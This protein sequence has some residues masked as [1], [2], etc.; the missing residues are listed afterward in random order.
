MRTSVTTTLCA[1]ALLGVALP[2]LAT[3]RIKDIAS[4]RGVRDNQLIGYGLVVGLNG[5]GD[6]TGTEFT[7]QSLAG[8]LAGMGITVDA[9]EIQVKNVAAVI[10]TASLPP[11]ARAGSTLDAMVSSL[12]DATSLEGGTLAMTP[13]YGADGEVFAV[14]Q[15]P[16]SVGG[17][18]EQGG[19]GSSVTKNHPTVGR[20]AS[21]ALVERELAF[22]LTDRRDFTLA[23]HDPD[24]TT[25]RRA[26]LAIN[27]AI[28]AEV[29]ES[30]DSGTLHVSMPAEWSAGV[31]DFLARVEAV[32]LQPDR[33]ARVVFNERT[34]T[35]VMGAE[36]TISKVA[37]AHGSLAVSIGIFNDVSQPLPFSEGQT[38][39][40]TNDEVEV[41]EE[42]ARLTVV[43]GP[44][45]IEEL[46]R[47]LNAIGVTPRDLIAILQAIKAAG[48]LPA[49]L[50]LM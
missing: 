14:A 33:V 20:V 30:G 22:S 19:G 23:L 15:G 2:A 41:E 11:F 44:V 40:V 12:G 50:E 26:A 28:G 36:V 32:R 29:A 5:T 6:K 16:V 21:G 43:Q 47:G 49:E 39:P 35:I 24:F 31:V 9:D 13:L 18:A 37:V 7:R 38:T 3:T 4:V 17:F 8:V 34:G 10:V 42:E 46:V 48:A 45:T 1:V 25:S 27:E